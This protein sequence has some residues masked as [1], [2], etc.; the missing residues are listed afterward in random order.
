MSTLSPSPR[1]CSVVL[2][3]L[4][5]NPVSFG[6]DSTS[7]TTNS[8]ELV[9]A[10]ITALDPCAGSPNEAVCRCALE[11][12]PVTYDESVP[13]V[14]LDGDKSPTLQATGRTL[15]NLIRATVVSIAPETNA[16]PPVRL[17]VNPPAT[18]DPGPALEI[19]VH[20]NPSF[21]DL[22][23]VDTL[24]LPRQLGGQADRLFASIWWHSP[25][26]TLAVTFRGTQTP[27]EFHLDTLVSSQRSL[28]YDV[29]FDMKASEGFALGYLMMRD[30]LLRALKPYESRA[31]L[32]LVA[33]HSLGGAIAAI[34][35][36]DIDLKLDFDDVFGMTFGQPRV[37]A[38]FS[39]QFADDQ[40]LFGGASILRVICESDPVPTVPA[41]A[42]TGNGVKFKHTTN[43]VIYFDDPSSA[44]G[45]GAEWNH[46]FYYDE[47]FDDEKTRQYGLTKVKFATDKK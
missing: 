19:L 28:K 6:Q 33:G 9:D 10:M 42:V 3:S 20:T 27:F 45:K 14:L 18:P 5:I 35:T 44:S 38:P 16:E 47:Y 40:K 26:S 34:A 24:L 15:M 32:V 2:L 36:M 17:Y 21:K 7:K 29:G 30:K 39:A 8:D 13:L 25:S 23:L 12:P 11:F 1:V 41:A 43:S 31:S 37:F 22:E 4:A 46:H